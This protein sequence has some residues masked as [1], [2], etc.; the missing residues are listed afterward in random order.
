MPLM[1]WLSTMEK[2]LLHMIV[3]M[4]DGVV[5]VHIAMEEDGGLDR[6]AVIL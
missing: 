6:V 5:T 3:I 2:T 4:M 1:E